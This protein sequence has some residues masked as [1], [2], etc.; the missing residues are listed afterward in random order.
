MYER[1]RSHRHLMQSVAYNLP[2]YIIALV[3]NVTIIIVIRRCISKERAEPI[4]TR[5][6]TS[7]LVMEMVEGGS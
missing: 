4:L 5:N 6:D 1:S 2:I 3:N 7:N